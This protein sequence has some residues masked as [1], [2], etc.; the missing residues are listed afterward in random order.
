MKAK[1][2][3][4]NWQLSWVTTQRQVISHKANENGLF[5]IDQR[6]GPNLLSICPL[7]DLSF[8]ICKMKGSSLSIAIASY[9]CYYCI[10]NQVCMLGG[11]PMG[12]PL[13]N[14]ERGSVGLQLSHEN[15][16]KISSIQIGSHPPL[17][18]GQGPSPYWDQVFN[19]YL[20]QNIKD[21][22]CWPSC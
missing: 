7:F 2:N 6:S 8:S 14:W 21:I 11:L 9:Y 16:H 5:K 10:E 17:P 18:N 19:W 15:P 22:T 12:Q 20:T 1:L 4:H 13:A 3:H